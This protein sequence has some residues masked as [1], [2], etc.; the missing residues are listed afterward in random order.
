MIGRGTAAAA[1]SVGEVISGISGET[2]EKYTENASTRTCRVDDGR[3]RED[4]RTTL[5]ACS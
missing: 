1:V 3:V 4:F 5:V 2:F